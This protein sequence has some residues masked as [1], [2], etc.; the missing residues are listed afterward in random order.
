MDNIVWRNDF[1]QYKHSGI[2]ADSNRK[3]RETIEWIKVKEN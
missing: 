1:I 2:N 3:K